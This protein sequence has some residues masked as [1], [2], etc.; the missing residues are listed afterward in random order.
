METGDQYR[1]YGPWG[2]RDYL[3]LYLSNLITEHLQ[4]IVSTLTPALLLA[5]LHIV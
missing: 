1:P 4:E 2:S 5:R 3:Y